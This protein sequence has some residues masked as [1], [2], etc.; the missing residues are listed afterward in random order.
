VTGVPDPPG[1][2]LEGT[3]RPEPSWL[4]E[5]RLRIA[6]LVG[7]IETLAVAFTSTTWRFA[8]VLGAAAFTFYLLVGRRSTNATVRDL[9]WTAAASQILPVVLPVVIYA[10]GLAVVAGVVVLAVVVAAMLYLDRR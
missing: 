5:N 1:P 9:A 6:V 4:R 7:A 8:L 2:P 3:P 10:V